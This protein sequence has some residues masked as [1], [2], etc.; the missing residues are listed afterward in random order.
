MVEDYEIALA[1]TDDFDAILDLQERSLP[2]RHG[3]LSAR[4]PRAWFEAAI[5]AMLIIAAR[6]AGRVVGYLVSSAWRLM[7]RCPSFRRCSRRTPFSLHRS[8]K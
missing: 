4:F 8:R 1:T 7:P 3:T 5:T 6:R 2:H